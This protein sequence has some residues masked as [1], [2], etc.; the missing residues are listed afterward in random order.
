MP[1]LQ[2]LNAFDIQAADVTVWAIKRSGGLGGAL[3]VYTARWIEIDANLAAAIRG[4]VQAARDGIAEVKQYGLLA[5][6]N[7]GASAL[8]I[9]ADETNAPLVRDACADPTPQRKIKSLKEITNSAFYAIKL[10]VGPNAIL[11]VRKTN[12]S[13]SSRVS[14]GLMTAIF[15]DSILTLDDRP[16]FSLSNSID[17]FAVDDEVLVL[18]KANFES[19]LS[20]REAHIEDFALLQQEPEFVKAFS[21]IEPLVGFVGTNKL[22]LRRASA[23]KAKGYYRDANF[24]DRLRAQAARLHLNI[25]FDAA[26]RIDPTPET[27][28]DIMQALLDHRLISTLTEAI[29]DVDDAQA[30]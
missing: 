9:P 17:F 30:V 6:D 22:Q 25:T 1:A 8:S 11:A 15:Q 14:A 2:T 21:A 12:A 28:R 29:Y 16:R 23:I 4:A 18:D 26:G 19:V 7:D 24:L 5:H 10:V 27:C 13:W 3:P 20:Y